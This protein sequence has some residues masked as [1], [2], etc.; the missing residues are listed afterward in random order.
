MRVILVI[1]I[2]AGC[3]MQRIA[4]GQTEIH[5]CVDAEGGIVY[6]QLPC[7]DHKP[8]DMETP[9]TSEVTESVLPEPAAN[10]VLVS[11]DPQEDAGAEARKQACKKRHRDAIDAIDAEIRSNYSREKDA[12]Y[13]QRLLTLTRKLREC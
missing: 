13:K 4:F 10:D 5:K 7:T 11:D 8:A 3:C 9:K 6:S 2:L 12:D 1:L